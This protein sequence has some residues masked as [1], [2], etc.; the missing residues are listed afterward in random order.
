MAHLLSTFLMSKGA[1][2][3]KKFH[4]TTGST[5]AALGAHE[6]KQL[7]DG[8]EKDG[9][10]VVFIDEAYQLSSGVNPGGKVILDYL[11]SVM[12]NLRGKIIFM[13]A[14]YG[15]DME[16]LLNHNIGFSSRFPNV[17]N[18]DN[19]IEYELLCIF[20]SQITKKYAG[21]MRL[22]GGTTGPYVRI[23]AERLARGS[24]AASFGNARAVENAIARIERRQATRIQQARRA[25]PNESVDIFQLTKNDIIGPEPTTALNSCPAWNELNQMVGLNKVKQEL[26]TFCGLVIHNY[27]R[28]LAGEKVFNL[29]LNRVFLGPPGTGKTTVAKLYGQILAHLGLLSNGDVVV[30]NPSDFVGG[31]IDKSEERTRKILASTVGKVLVIDEAYGFLSDQEEGHTDDYRSAVIDTLVSEVQSVSGEDRCVL[32]L[33]YEHPMRKM[34]QSVNQGLTRRFPLSSAFVFEKFDDAAL[35]QVLK[36]KLNQ[37]S[38]QVDVEATAAALGVLRLERRRPISETQERWTI[39]STRRKSGT[40][41]DLMMEGHSEASSRPPI[42]TLTLTEPREVRI[43]ARSSAVKLAAPHCLSSWKGIN[44]VP[45]DS[46]L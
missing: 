10:S 40:K 12:E 9:G 3:G 22:E 18:F 8:I 30:K 42:L 23:V 44:C 2:P 1:V 28:E 37:L 7:L 24:G 5:L 20:E 32:L 25:G 13:L 39:C 31:Y 43:F 21:K 45:E 34:F 11:F 29:S 41:R 4:E 17:F 16:T 36:L 27:N 6:I 14:G 26:K 19:Y 46:E 33:G 15:K 35:S 38:I